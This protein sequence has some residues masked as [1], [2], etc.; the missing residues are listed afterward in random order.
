MVRGLRRGHDSSFGGNG[1]I[2]WRRQNVTD[3]VMTTSV[4]KNRLPERD[5]AEERDKTVVAVLSGARRSEAGKRG[6]NRRGGK[7]AFR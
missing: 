5:V 3:L 1:G 6:Y 4:A 7:T 2:L